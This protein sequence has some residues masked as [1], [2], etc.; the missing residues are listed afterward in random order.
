MKLQ[1][2]LEIRIEKGPFYAL[3]SCRIVKNRP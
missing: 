3:E 1:T 2:L